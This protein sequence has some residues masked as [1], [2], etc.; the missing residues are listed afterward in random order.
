MFRASVFLFYPIQTL[1]GNPPAR[2][3]R[4]SD[5]KWLPAK[6]NNASEIGLSDLLWDFLRLCLDLDVKRRPVVE[7]AVMCL[8]EAASNWHITTLPKASE[9]GP[10]EADRADPMNRP[11]VKPKEP[12]NESPG[13]SREE[14]IAP[15]ATSESRGLSSVGGM[16]RTS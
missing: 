15:V 8:A 3:S 1:T 11:E 6:P 13:K 5:P 10:L 9:F 16:S 14:L 7:E 4:P 12:S 2:G